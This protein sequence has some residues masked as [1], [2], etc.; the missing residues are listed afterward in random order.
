MTTSLDDL[1]L[2]SLAVPPKKGHLRFTRC[3]SVEGVDPFD[4]VEWSYRD[5]IIQ[6]S[7]GVV[8]EQKRVE[9][10]SSWS[11]TAVN[12]V[13]SKYFRGT[14]GTR[15]R[16]TSVRQL[17]GRVV[18]TIAAWGVE[19][20]YFRAGDDAQVFKE[21]LTALIIEQRMAFNSPVWF[22]VGTEDRPQV[23]A[24]FINGV[25]DSMESIL[26]LARTE[27]MLFKFGSGTGSN[28][29]TIR[30][31]KEP[32]AGGGEASGPVSFMKG[33]DAF[34]GV[35]KSGGKT[36]RAAKMVLLNADH[37]DVV[38]F[39]FCK[40]HEEKKA[41][42]LIDAGYDGGFNVPGGAYDSIQ[43]QNA[44]HS[45]RVTD[46]FMR[47]ATGEAK[48]LWPLRA[49]TTG[50][51]LEEMEASELLDHIAMAAWEC[52]DPG[53]Q[54]DT[55]INDWH[56]CP[57]TARINGS[58]PCVTGD[59]LV[60]TSEGLVRI[61]KMLTRGWRVIG[62]DGKEHEI[63][64]AFQTGTKPVYELRT[65]SGYRLRLTADHKVKTLNRG[66][67]RAADLT[68]DDLV[69]LQ[70]SPFGNAALDPKFA[71]T[72]GLFL[73]D[74]CVSEGSAQ[75]VMG[76]EDREIIEDAAAC[77]N[78]LKTRHESPG[79]I[80]VREVPTG[81]KIATTA[82]VT[83]SALAEYAVLD[84]GSDGKAFTETFFH[85]DK[86][87]QAAILRGLFTTD[88]T[89]ANYGGKSHY[90]GLDS[91]SEKLL[92]Q[93]QLVLL[94]FGVK[95]KLYFDRRANRLTTLMPDGKGG[96][97][98][99]ETLPLH[100]LRISRASR[101]TFE[102]EIGFLPASKKAR[103]LRE[104]NETVEVYADPLHDRVA[105]L[106]PVGDAP[107][108]DL[109]EPRTHH[110]VANGVIVHNCGEYMHVDDSA[111]NL[112]SLNLMKFR[113]HD[114]FD[115]EAFQRA[116]EL[117]V[118]AQEILVDFASYPTEK[119]AKNS[120]DMRQLGLGY[121]NLGA[122]L[123][124]KGLPY[125][126][127]EGRELAASIT[128]LMCGTAYATS[129]R[130]AEVKGPFRVY[131]ANQAAM[132]NVIEKHQEASRILAAEATGVGRAAI[133]A[134][135][136]AAALGKEHGYRNAQ[137]TVLAPTGTIGFMMDCDT[138][139]VEP[140][141]ALV[142]FK[143]LVG[144]G[145]FKIV[146]RT[147]EQGLET[148]GYTRQQREAIRRWIDE[149][150]TIE[151]APGLWDEHLP[152]FDC[153]FAPTNGSRSITPMGHVRMMAAVQ[154]FLSGAISKTV[155]MPGDATVEDV[156]EVYVEGWRLGLKALAV[157]RDGCKRTQPLSTSLDVKKE[158][159]EDDSRAETLNVERLAKDHGFTRRRRLPEERPAITHK[160]EI[161]G[162]EG[163]A[164]VGLYDDG[165]PGELF[166]TMS[167]EGSV[168]SGL[169]DVFATSVSM[170]LQYG[171]PLEVLVKKFSHVRF[172]PSGMTGNSEIPMAKSIVDYIFRWLDHKFGEVSTE[173][174][175]KFQVNMPGTVRSQTDAP[176]C[177]TC[178]SIMHRS[179]SCYKCSN[180]G[181]TSGCS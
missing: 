37:P 106:E 13:A 173:T 166:L 115:V 79:T 144:G 171:V 87:S 169:L 51:V 98:E 78:A 134:W 116:V 180:C 95:S 86:E 60:A 121:A 30:S 172:E 179:G 132:S 73:G 47:L 42:A 53:I 122:L 105:T 55:T 2:D 20:G 29:S 72:I 99:Y 89:V 103:A 64:P 158:E 135:N 11:D 100:S 5:A 43:F 67:V 58:N 140:E 26:E 149:N 109:T 130:I 175:P 56:T 177:S 75:L 146:N 142:K 34:A 145:H 44:N 156:R 32:L 136:A 14:P 90:V 139:G 128:A 152:V 129:A 10:P 62:A 159:E 38:D 118:T 162:F 111:C 168:V 160:F 127:D 16:E 123:M 15:A 61:D 54:F 33:F 137:T 70:G 81:V 101:V 170:C 1:P 52:G 164:T 174:S 77:L 48:G 181:S 66:D 120:R 126:S 40:V 96:V 119:I 113:T 92:A 80:N 23:S 69:I 178:G 141:L 28:L 22:N 110:F 104:L 18:D 41:H 84:E 151:G 31:S 21:E 19:G 112:A 147:V 167:K 4:A 6:G 45:V 102:R 143:K 83:V 165:S 36:R 155:N 57:N 50:E 82:A 65:R 94:S 88:G 25:E 133:S 125:D 150:D 85:L 8:F 7:E 59:T 114:G 117:T 157:Y 148:L 97:S 71:T 27:G 107:V 39:V 12:V 138:T 176:P 46:E 154:P 68:R 63:A 108:Y 24:C 124:S 163:Y 93:V 161:N 74:G 35:I 3:F 153:A 9:A 131:E 17:I 91:T 49:V 76:N